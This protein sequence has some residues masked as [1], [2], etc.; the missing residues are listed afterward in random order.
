METGWSLHPLL[1]RDTIWVG[2][3]ALSRVLA[4]ND[5]DYPWLVLVP[6]RAG[7]TE[8]IDLG[9]EQAQLMAEIARASHALKEA[10][11]CDKLNVAA[12]GNVVQ[13]LHVH[14]V[15]RRHDDPLWPKPVWGAS[16]GRPC[17]RGALQRFVET[18]QRRL[19]VRP[20][21]LYSRCR[22]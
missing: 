18:M 14:I 7:A 21:G 11:G 8:I 10:T 17:D 6:R 13:Q 15:A 19:D 20:T 5:A 3:F 12:I 9:A 22:C 2:D 1:Q 4:L 16:P